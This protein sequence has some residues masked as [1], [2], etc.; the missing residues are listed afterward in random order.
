MKKPLIAIAIT[1][2]VIGAVVAVC[3]IPALLLVIGSFSAVFIR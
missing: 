3:F 2:A 1:L